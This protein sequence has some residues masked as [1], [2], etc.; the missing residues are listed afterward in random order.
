MSSLRTQ[1]DQLA[2][3]VANVI[4]ALIE[5]ALECGLLVLDAADL[6]L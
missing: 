5:F 2:E 1:L 3:C 4:E 6:L